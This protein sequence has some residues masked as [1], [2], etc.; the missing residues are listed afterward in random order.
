MK[1]KFKSLLILLS[2]MALVLS[3]TIPGWTIGFGD[4]Q[5]VLMGALVEKASYDDNQQAGYAINEEVARAEIDSIATYGGGAKEIFARFDLYLEFFDQNMD[6]VFSDSEKASADVQ[7]LD[8]VVQYARSK[9]LKVYMSAYG[10]WDWFSS[11]SW[12]EGSGKASREQW[13]D[14]EAFL[15]DI[16]MARYNP[17]YVQVCPEGR[18]LMGR[19][20]EET[21]SDWW[22]Y[23]EIASEAIRVKNANV[24]TLVVMNFCTL[25]SEEQYNK[26]GASNNRGIWE[27]LN[28]Y[29]V[30][31]MDII[32]FDAYWQEVF[33]GGLS[34]IDT[35]SFW[36][37]YIWGMTEVG[38]LHDYVERI[39]ALPDNGVVDQGT[40]MMQ[41]TWTKAITN[42]DGG[43]YLWFYN[44]RGYGGVMLSSCDTWLIDEN[45]NY[46]DEAELYN[47]L[48]T[49]YGK[50]AASPVVAISNP[51]DGAT[52]SGSVTIQLSAAD[53]IGVT[54]LVLEILGYEVAS[55][56]TGGT[57][58]YDWDTTTAPEDA[59]SSIIAIAQDGDDNVVSTRADVKVDNQTNPDKTM[60][61]A[62]I[63]M[64]GKKYL[65][66]VGVAE[67]GMR[68]LDSSGN[69]VVGATVSGH[70]SGITSDSDSGVTDANGQYTARSDISKV[71]L[72]GTFTWTIDNV[73]KSG[74][75]YNSTANDET[76]DWIY[77]P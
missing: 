14:A 59:L 35:H 28:D 72:P 53:D 7:A 77:I 13:H 46:L 75:S 44:H 19:Q 39:G 36:S 54:S 67:A 37:G 9:G 6:G 21:P 69:P 56:D 33:D 29:P 65:A 27:R 20:L 64:R 76:S 40:E 50:K 24:N 41:D 66:G 5:N 4:P 52:I 49:E 1:R 26:Y 34:Y 8:N 11:T 45:Y 58:T 74:W 10:V 71:K 51:G 18:V 47:S 68:I 32:G 43:L 60:Y 3:I 23:E 63:Y 61:S 31:Q 57:H 42:R 62:K 2:L 30:P 55:W 22:W 16:I 38:Q 48:I 25:E 70:W 17:D 12:G 15:I 73:E